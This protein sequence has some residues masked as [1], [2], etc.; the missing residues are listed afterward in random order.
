MTVGKAM[1]QRFGT[2]DAQPKYKIMTVNDND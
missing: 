1:V 2:D